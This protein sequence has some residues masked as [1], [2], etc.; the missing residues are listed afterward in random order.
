MTYLNDKEEEYVEDNREDNADETKNNID[1]KMNEN[2]QIITTTKF[3]AVANID[4]VG[5]SKDS[6]RISKSSEGGE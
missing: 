2:I 3:A 6:I 4:N 1:N 5:K